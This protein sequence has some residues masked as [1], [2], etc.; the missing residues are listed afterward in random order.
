MF[1]LISA[2]VEVTLHTFG[3]PSRLVIA[4]QKWFARATDTISPCIAC[5]TLGCA[6]V[7]TGDASTSSS[8]ARK[9]KWFAANVVAMLFGPGWW[10]ARGPEFAPAQAFRTHADANRGWLAMMSA[11]S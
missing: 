10:S 11:R 8:I 4:T 5:V 6:P 9:L 1:W 3:T 7:T 2:A